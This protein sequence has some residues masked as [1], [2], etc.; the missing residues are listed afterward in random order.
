MCLEHCSEF[1]ILHKDI[2]GKG[3]RKEGEKEGREGEIHKKGSRRKVISNH[4]YSVKQVPNITLG[5]H[6][7]INVSL[8][9]RFHHNHHFKH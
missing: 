5:Y 6:R 9:D 1:R 4:V 3:E 8:L 2:C 7:I